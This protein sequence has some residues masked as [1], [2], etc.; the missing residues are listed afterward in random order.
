MKQF[1]N[2]SI[3]GSGNLATNLAVALE[4][5][6]HSI[7]EIYSRNSEHAQRLVDRLYDA[8]LQHDLDFSESRSR[9]FIIAVKDSE[10]GYVADKIVVPDDDCLIVHTSGSVSLEILESFFE[11]CGVFYP[12]QTF[13]IDH[14]IPFRDVP[15]LIEGNSKSTTKELIRLGETLSRSVQPANSEDRM[16]IHLAAVF[17]SNFSN[18]FISIAKELLDESA[19]DYKILRPLV[20]EAVHKGFSMD[21]DKAQTGPARRRDTGVI[22]KHLEVIKEHPD[23]Q[24]IYQKISEHIIK[25][26]S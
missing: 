8:R 11:R 2:I 14:L 20:K 19:I 13:S 26:Y 17:T 7:F 25:K 15:I 9:I 16:M 6:G 4:S 1:Q 22:R 24:E 21:P 12:L 5:E 23:L 3:I 10:I 18:H